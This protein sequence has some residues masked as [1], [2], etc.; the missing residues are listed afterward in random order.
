MTDNTTATL[1]AETETDP[2]LEV[3][4]VESFEPEVVRP[5]RFHNRAYSGMDDPA[6][7]ALAESIR[8]DGQQQ[9]GLARR[10]PDGDTHLVEAIFGV[11]RLEACRRAGV[12]WRAEVRD[13]SLPDSQCA[14]FMHD[15]NEWTE[16]VSP[17]EN[18]LQWQA[19]LKADVF[20]SQ[21]SLADDLGCHRGTVSRGVRTVTT[22]FGEAWIERLVH[23]V[24]HE[25]TGRSADRLAD[26]LSDAN[27]RRR[28]RRRAAKLTPG[29]VSAPALYAALIGEAPPRTDGGET[30]FERRRG[31]GRGGAIAAKIERD[32]NGGFSVSVRPHN[33]TPAELAELAE[34]VTALL[35]IE[36]APAAGVRLGRMLTASLSPDEA[37]ETDQAWL[38]GCIWASARA[39]GLDWDRWRCMAA[40]QTLRTQ[41]VGWERAVVRVIGGRE[42]DPGGT[43]DNG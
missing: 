29:T 24:M 16:G 36:T 39:S 2:V 40:A 12:R 25:F 1:D 26:A 41:P 8:R 15:E 22:L 27:T 28:A 34:E 20:P 5:W 17:L 14:A 37:R 43:P 42:A 4:H 38:E 9:L 30:L 32:G 21:S 7:D 35:A 33:Q 31:R 13:A 3:V 11:R 23:P 10:L 6:L 19:M 18:A